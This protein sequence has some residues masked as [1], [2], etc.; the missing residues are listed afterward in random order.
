MTRYGNKVDV[1]RLNHSHASKLES[2]VCALLQLREKAGEIRDLETQCHVYLSRAR[3]CYIAD[4][5]CV[6]SRTEATLYVEA[7]GFA[8]DRWPTI[9]KL[10][11]S[12]GPGPLE[13]WKGSYTRPSLD[14][15]IKPVAI[16]EGGN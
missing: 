16:T 12:Y 4:F 7:K 13:I 9:K 8:N 14:E 2:A 3:I 10:W 6:D 11:K 15:V 1:C 5:K